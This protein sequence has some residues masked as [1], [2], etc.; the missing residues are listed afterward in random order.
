MATVK[1]VKLMKD[2]VMVTPVVLIDSVKNLDGTIYKDAVNDSLNSMFKIKNITINC[3]NSGTMNVDM[4]DVNY[5]TLIYMNCTSSGYASSG[6]Y[7]TI[8]LNTNNTAMLYAYLWDDSKESTIGSQLY[9]SNN[10]ISVTLHL[11]ASE[12]KNLPLLVIPL[13]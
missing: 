4:P 10:T 5:P 1:E 11:N 6:G 13:K 8:N 7:N 2:G 12:T 9:L 3:Y